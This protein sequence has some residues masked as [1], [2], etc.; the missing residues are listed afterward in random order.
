LNPPDDIHIDAQIALD[1]AKA[2]TDG[3][4]LFPACLDAVHDFID[5]VRRG[6]DAVFDARDGRFGEQ[7]GRRGRLRGGGFH[8]GNGGSLRRESYRLNDDGF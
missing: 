2:I 4:D 1:T 5:T 7:F 3:I 8:R 6:H